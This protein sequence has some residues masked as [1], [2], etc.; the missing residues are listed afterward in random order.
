MNA[1]LECV[2]KAGVKFDDHGFMFDVPTKAIIECS[3]NLTD[4]LPGSLE[5]DSRRLQNSE[6][7]KSKKNRKFSCIFKFF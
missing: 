5:N 3:N 1:V 7:E 4:I 2:S 6:I